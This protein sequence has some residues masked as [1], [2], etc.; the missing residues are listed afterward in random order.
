[1]STE[2][3]APGWQPPDTDPLHRTLAWY[4]RE[5]DIASDLIELAAQNN[6]GTEHIWVRLRLFDGL[7]LLAF[8]LNHIILATPGAAGWIWPEPTE[9]RW[10]P[11]KGPL[12]G[13]VARCSC[14]KAE[15]SS[16]KLPFF[17]FCGAGSREAAEVCMCGYNQLAHDPEF[18]KRNCEKRTV[19]EQGKCLGF[20]ARGPRKYDRFYCGCRG[21]D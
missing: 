9:W 6:L 16:P 4:V 1:M 2:T 17:E 13:R 7:A 20:L 14:G 15:L 19:V 8:K 18:T 5:A 11:E 21:W 12:A 10:K 3:L